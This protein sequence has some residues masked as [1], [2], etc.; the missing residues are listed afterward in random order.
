MKHRVINSYVLIQIS[1]SRLQETKE[2]VW[3]VFVGL[4]FS[5]RKN[6]SW[7]V[8]FKTTN[9]FMYNCMYE[10]HKTQAKLFKTSAIHRNMTEIDIHSM[11]LTS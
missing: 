4:L 8:Y 10:K 5:K 3:G 6:A 11:T 2:N 7:N 9:N 1:S